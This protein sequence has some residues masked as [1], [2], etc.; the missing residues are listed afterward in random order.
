MITVEI[1]WDDLSQDKQDELKEAGFYHENIY[2]TPL[3]IIE[4]SEENE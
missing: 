2:L 1:Y 4:K 3:A